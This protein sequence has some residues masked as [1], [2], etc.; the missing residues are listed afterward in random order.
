MFLPQIEEILAKISAEAMQD[1]VI[2]EDEQRDID[3][4]KAAIAKARTGVTPG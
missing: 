2:D 3:A 4:A 1:G